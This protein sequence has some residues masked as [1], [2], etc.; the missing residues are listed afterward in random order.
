MRR[1]ASGL[2]VRAPAL[3]ETLKAKGLLPDFEGP[4]DYT[5]RRTSDSDIYFVSGQRAAERTFRVSGKQPEVWDVVSGTM[6][7]AANW[8]A[9]H[10]GRTIVSLD[11]PENGSAFIVFR[12]PGQP[13]QSQPP[14]PPKPEEKTLSGPWTVSFEPGRGA[15]ESAVFEQLAAWN[16]HPNEG[17]KFFSGKA[18]ARSKP[19]KVSRPTIR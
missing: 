4:C 15:P 7:D 17:I 8:R 19:T 3:N 14:V 13:P 5:H 12:K 6:S 2:W 18:S 1:L 16:E 11:L 9:S 10:D